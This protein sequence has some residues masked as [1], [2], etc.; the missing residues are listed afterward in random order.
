M[1]CSALICCS[2]RLKLDMESAL[3]LLITESVDTYRKLESVLNDETENMTKKANRL[4]I[5]LTFFVK[6]IV[7]LSEQYPN[8]VGT[9]LDTFSEFLGIM[10]LKGET[11]FPYMDQPMKDRLER[12]I[13]LLNHDEVFI[14]RI[15]DM[16]KFSEFLLTSETKPTSA[17]IR[18]QIIM[19]VIETDAVPNP[20][21]LRLLDVMLETYG[22][23]E[24]ENQK[25]GWLESPEVPGIQVK[26]FS[27]YEWILTKV[28]RFISGIKPDEF[29]ALELVLFRNLFGDFNLSCEL[30]CDILCFIGRLGSAE[31]CYSLLESTS[32]LCVQIDLGYYSSKQVWLGSLVGRLFNFLGTQ[33][34]NRWIEKYSPVEPK[35][36]ILWSRINL[37]RIDQKETLAL[38]QDVS[39][40]RYNL[41]LDESSSKQSILILPDILRIFSGLVTRNLGEK[42]RSVVITIWQKMAESQFVPYSKYWLS[43]FF[44]A[45]TE[46]TVSVLPN[47]TFTELDT[48]ISTLRLLAG[49]ARS[50]GQPSF[51][52]GNMLNILLRES[53]L[54]WIGQIEVGVL[55]FRYI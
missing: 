36:L 10:F 49:S 54:D 41:M 51:F 44:N 7:N 39:F 4:I 13:F 52:I 9:N 12:D 8:L 18:V 34:Q 37:Q 38:L 43:D 33:E 28:S 32:D 5:A 26:I 48:L 17:F 47:L 19:S 31:L 55:I 46:L 11:L 50:Q 15:P 6:M 53:E 30:C 16:D 1:I 21:K 2:P 25:T 45:L 23:C 14:L 20:I 42:Y 24:A 22:Y 40:S 29:S 35:N 27:V 3:V